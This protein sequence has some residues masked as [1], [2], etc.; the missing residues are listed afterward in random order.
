MEPELEQNSAG[1]AQ[2]PSTDGVTDD[3]PI[4]PEPHPNMNLDVRRA[5]PHLSSE[6]RVR[7]QDSKKEEK[8]QWYR[9]RRF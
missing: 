6:D 4:T 7:Q 9:D 1:S 8:R 3:L 5:S 2:S